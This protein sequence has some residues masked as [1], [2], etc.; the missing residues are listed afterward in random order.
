MPIRSALV[1]GVSFGQ[2]F[3]SGGSWS[4]SH[5]TLIY[6]RKFCTTQLAPP[7]RA[8][9]T[10]NFSTAEG[11][12]RNS[13]NAVQNL[14]NFMRIHGREFIVR[15]SQQDVHGKGIHRKNFMAQNSW[16]EV[17]C[18][19]TSWVNVYVLK[20]MN[21]YTRGRLSGQFIEFINCSSPIFSWFSLDFLSIPEINQSAFSS[22]GKT[23]SN[24]LEVTTASRVLADE[25]LDESQYV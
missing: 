24:V 1:T 11:M 2:P 16:W 12:R 15:T 23:S 25:S 9:N 14:L 22:R 19:W 18:S 6:H 3:T 21:S 7:K 13:P 4:R 20:F 5:R 8:F 10:L 17:R